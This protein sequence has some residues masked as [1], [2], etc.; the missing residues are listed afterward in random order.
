MA[1]DM[2]I[3]T[4]D[5]LS[6]NPTTISI[7]K[8]VLGVKSKLFALAD[9]QRSSVWDNSEAR[10]LDLFRSM[11]LGIPVGVLYFWN[12]EGSE[13]DKKRSRSLEGL[14]HYY[15]AEKITHLIL[16]GQQRTT[17]LCRLVLSRFESQK[18]LMKRVVLNL[19][20]NPRMS[21]ENIFRFEK[22]INY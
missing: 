8:L 5:F 1:N 6:E 11:Y 12:V 13:E 18:H 3:N 20:K 21:F 19:S 17:T 10:Q 2:P 7:E 22:D 15:D 9:I 4:D 14:E 16:D